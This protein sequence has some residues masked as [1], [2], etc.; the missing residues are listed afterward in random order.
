MKKCFKRISLCL[1]F[2]A[3][4]NFMLLWCIGLSLGG[5]A[6][7]GKVERGHYYLGN[8]GDLTEVSESTWNYRYY[9]EVSVL[10]THP[11]GIGS[12]VLADKLDRTNFIKSQRKPHG[13]T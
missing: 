10:I 5:S 11:L 8:H 3:I 1:F 6:L 2:L 13:R 12:A 9:H 7:N 4:A